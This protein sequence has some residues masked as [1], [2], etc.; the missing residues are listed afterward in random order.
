MGPEDD[1]GRT[2]EALFLA[3][4]ASRELRVKSAPLPYWTDASGPRDSRTVGAL[5]A[6]PE[7][8]GGVVRSCAP[9]RVREVPSA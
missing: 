3:K 2:S 6:H 4:R 1:L 7:R 8:R 9:G 5:E